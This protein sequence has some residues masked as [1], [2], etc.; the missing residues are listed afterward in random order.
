MLGASFVPVIFT[1][2]F[3]E[4]TQQGLE[5]VVGYK[6]TRTLDITNDSINVEYNN[7]KYTFS[8]KQF[9]ENKTVC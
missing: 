3:C 7:E 9:L 1:I 5:Y 8:K 4:A 2:K 6:A